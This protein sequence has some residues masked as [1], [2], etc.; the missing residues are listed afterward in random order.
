ML[1]LIFGTWKAH[2]TI[3]NFQLSRSLEHLE[4]LCNCYRACP[5]AQK[6]CLATERIWKARL[7]VQDHHPVFQQSLATDE[8]QQRQL[9]SV[10]KQANVWANPQPG[11]GVAEWHVHHVATMVTHFGHATS[12]GLCHL[13]F[14]GMPRSPRWSMVV[15]GGHL[16]FCHTLPHRLCLTMPY[17]GN[18]M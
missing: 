2:E 5:W 15:Y 7:Y 10:Q 18:F 6:S 13:H 14:H 9:R 4:T 17:F 11:V 16:Q 1:Q 8:E 3:L 12:K